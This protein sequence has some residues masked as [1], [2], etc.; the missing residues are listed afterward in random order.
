VAGSTCRSR[1]STCSTCGLLSFGYLFH[2]ARVTNVQGRSKWWTISRNFILRGCVGRQ[3]TNRKRTLSQPYPHTYIRVSGLSGGG[4]GCREG[5]EEEVDA[6]RHAAGPAEVPGAAKKN[7]SHGFSRVD[8]GRTEADSGD[9]AFDDGAARG[10]GT[11][12]GPSGTCARAG[13]LQTD[14][15]VA[16]RSSWRRTLTPSMSRATCRRARPCRAT[17]RRGV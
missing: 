10:R 16:G 11:R 4:G 7:M 1:I 14:G 2:A 3:H 9:R 5:E 13:G 17:P 6:A 8:M 15:A 12:R